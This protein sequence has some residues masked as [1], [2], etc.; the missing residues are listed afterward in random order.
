M[1]R[2]IMGAVRFL[3][4]MA[5]ATFV[6]VVAS[7]CGDDDTGNGSGNSPPQPTSCPS[8]CM[9][10]ATCYQPDPSSNCNGAWY[11]QGD[12]LW[13]C[14]PPQTGGPGDATVVFEAGTGEEGDDAA[15]EGEAGSD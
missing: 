13:H 14:A 10:G 6:G 5:L 4:T 11:C 12:S 8:P 3:A 15:A 1:N 9:P 2:G 7:A